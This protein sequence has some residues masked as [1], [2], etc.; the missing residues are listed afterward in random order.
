MQ[1]VLFPLPIH[2]FLSS[3]VLF[4][5]DDHVVRRLNG[6][7]G[8]NGEWRIFLSI[9][10][11]HTNVQVI[12]ELFHLHFAFL[13]LKKQTIIELRWS[14]LTIILFTCLGVRIMEHE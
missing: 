10:S 8:N 6:A 2:L 3:T 4:L 13:I 7:K 12:L 9:V 5:T 1:I 11:V 14:C